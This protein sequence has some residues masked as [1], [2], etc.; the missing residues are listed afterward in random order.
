MVEAVDKEVMAKQERRVRATRAEGCRVEIKARKHAFVADEPAQGGGTDT[1]P[2]PREL[3]L[4]ALSA[5]ITVITNKVAEG[6]DFNV[7]AQEVEVRGTADPRG[8]KDPD[9][10]ISPN[11]DYVEAKIHLT[12][13]EPMSGWRSSSASTTGA[14]PSPRS[15]ARAAA[16]W[17]RSG[18]SSGPEGVVEKAPQTGCSPQ[19][20]VFT[21]IPISR[22]KGQPACRGRIYAPCFSPLEHGSHDMSDIY[23]RYTLPR[24]TTVGAGPRACPR[25]TTQGVV[26]ICVPAFQPPRREG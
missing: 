24:I 25:G 2:T 12:T 7:V 18:S 11:F 23:V 3:A 14:A 13:D 9:N 20:K 1:G 16:N 17:W 19:S 4:G 6:L 8:A 22:A 26:P 5:C 10:G 21:V 15:T